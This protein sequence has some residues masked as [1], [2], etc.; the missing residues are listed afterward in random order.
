MLENELNC[1]KKLILEADKRAIKNQSIVEEKDVKSIKSKFERLYLLFDD[2]IRSEQEMSPKIE[3]KFGNIFQREMLPYILLTEA[4]ERCYSKPRGYAGD[5][6]MIESIYQNNPRG[7]GRLGCVLDSCFL[8]LP[9]AQ[10]VRNRRGLLV[11]EIKKV[12]EK[13]NNGQ[14]NIM[15]IASGPAKEIFDIFDF[16]DNPSQLKIKLLDFDIQALSFVNEKLTKI[17]L[18][19]Q[20]ELLNENII[21]L[22]T[23]KRKLEIEKQDFIYSIGLIDYLKDETVVKLINYIYKILKPGG[24]VILGN[25]HS[26]N[27]NKA[28][29]DYV[30]DWRLIHRDENDMNRLFNSSKFQKTCTKIFFEERKINLF[31][32]CIK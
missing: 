20:V 8:D 10:A 30:L 32:E 18:N 24:K 21:Y 4:G 22:I 9:V 13:T 17:N 12:L 3:Q 1:F 25:F 27:P 19:N 5:Y 26:A 29:M 14:V 31:A 15:S 23:G 16:I 2:L 28:F 11:K 7:S 6:H